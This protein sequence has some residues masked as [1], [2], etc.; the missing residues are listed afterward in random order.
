MTERVLTAKK[1]PGAK[2]AAITQSGEWVLNHTF[3][4]RDDPKLFAT[5]EKIRSA[6]VIDTKFWRPARRG[7]I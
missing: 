5:L 2:I 4:H 6:G 1:I 7:E 3:S